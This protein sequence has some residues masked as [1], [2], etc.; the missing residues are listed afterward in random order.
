MPSRRRELA[1]S[2]ES[3]DS[4][5]SEMLTIEE[6]AARK[7]KYRVVAHGLP[8]AYPIIKTP[9]ERNLHSLIRPSY[10]TCANVYLLTTRDDNHALWQIAARSVHAL[11]LRSGASSF[12]LRYPLQVEI[13]NPDLSYHDISWC[14]RPD[15]M[16]ITLFNEKRSEI[17]QI[18]KAELS[19]VASAVCFHDR[20]RYSDRNTTGSV[21][22]P[23]VIVYCRPNVPAK[24][25]TAEERLACLFRD[26]TAEVHI[27]LLPGVVTNSFNI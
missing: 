23:T 8:L 12:N 17:L 20:I 22:Q 2:S 3:N 6:Y 9:P 15:L 7:D 25:Q 14:L 19:N 21:G 11:I 10:A 13:S 26:I 18:V 4:G 16:L 5:F 1:R 24:F 27:E